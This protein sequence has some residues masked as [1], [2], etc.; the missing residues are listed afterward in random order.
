MIV[1]FSHIPNS[2]TRLGCLISFI[3]AASFRNSST[4]IVSSYTVYG[5]KE[6][7]KKE[8]EDSKGWLD[9]VASVLHQ[10]VALFSQIKTIAWNVNM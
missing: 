1:V 5:K 2:C 10:M 9:A 8:S 7:K 4:S 3:T 6:K